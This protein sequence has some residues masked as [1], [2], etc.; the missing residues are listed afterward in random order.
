MNRSIRTTASLT[1]ILSACAAVMATAKE[2]VSICN[3]LFQDAVKK[4]RESNTE[5]NILERQLAYLCLQDAREEYDVLKM[6]HAKAK[7]DLRIFC[8][9]A[10][11]A[12]TRSGHAIRH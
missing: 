9:Q 3:D 8:Y 5:E 11:P 2:R 10:K 4:V 7:E 12:L 1:L 6:N